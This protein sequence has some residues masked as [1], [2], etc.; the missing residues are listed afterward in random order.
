LVKN[1]CMALGKPILRLP[2]VEWLHT[3]CDFHSGIL[4]VQWLACPLPRRRL[5]PL[6]G[7]LVHRTG[8]WWG[9]LPFHASR[10]VYF[11]NMFILHNLMEF[12][13]NKWGY[14]WL[15]LIACYVKFWC[16]SICFPFFAAAPPSKYRWCA[17]QICSTGFPFPRS[18]VKR[19]SQN[20]SDWQ[21]RNVL[22]CYRVG[23]IFAKCPCFAGGKP[24][25]RRIAIRPE[26][27]GDVVH[28][29]RRCVFNMFHDQQHT[30]QRNC[31]LATP[32]VK[33]FDCNY[34]WDMIL[35]CHKI[36]TWPR[37]KIKHPQLVS[38]M[39]EL[40]LFR[41]PDLVGLM[42]V[43]EIHTCIVMHFAVICLYDIWLYPSS[44]KTMV[45]TKK[46]MKGGFAWNLLHYKGH[47]SLL[48]FHCFLLNWPNEYDRIS[49]VIPASAV[50]SNVGRSVAAQ[51]GV[52]M[53]ALVAT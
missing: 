28:W 4:Q 14:Q 42:Q 10:K 41:T 26:K 7:I 33:L 11:K 34:W 53:V 31:L 2:E 15:A 20:Q 30:Q 24:A 22:G 3:L 39:V 29:Q 21:E 23:M 32:K 1:N 16:H 5:A 12:Q 25:S 52:E 48:V 35:I 50:S 27:E 19:V 13:E 49:W 9:N 40:Y 47:D 46:N 18:E 51:P 44:P 6:L 38:L 8:C 43:I 37:I 17:V 45:S 36:L